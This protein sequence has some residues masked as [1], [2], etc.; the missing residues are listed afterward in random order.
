[1]KLSVSVRRAAAVVATASTLV[2]LPVTMASRASAAT[3]CA[4]SWCG[5]GE[6]HTIAAPVRVFSSRNT[7]P[8]TPINDP[9]PGPI[10]LGDPSP[11]KGGVTTFDIDLLGLASGS[12]FTNPWLPAG[13]SAGDVLAVVAS[14]TV[15]SPGASGYAQAYPA[16]SPAGGS[17]VNFNPGQTTPNLAILRPNAQGMVTIGLA[18]KSGSADVL[19]DVFG[20]FSTSG[21]SSGD[22]SIAR[23]ARLRTVSPG[24]IVDTRQ[25]GNPLGVNGDL[26]V[27]VR[28][29][30]V[31][32]T[33]TRIVPPDPSITGAVLNVTA[34][35]PSQ[36]TYL[37]VVPEATGGNAPATSNLN[38]PAGQNVA[39]TVIVPIGADG[40]VHVYNAKGTTNVIVDVVG[41]MQTG[42]DE[43]TRAGRIVPL[44]A[45][46]RALDTRAIAFGAVPLGP[47]QAEEWSFAS[48]AAS[49]NVGGTSVGN[50]AAVIGNFTSARLG[51]QYPTVGV[52][53]YLS[54]YPAGTTCGAPPTV[55]NVNSREVGSVAN[56]AVF[57]YGPN[58][59]MCVYNARGY[60][61]Y[62]FDVSAVVLAD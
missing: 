24:R 18:G 34:V 51:R 16:G 37:S 55:S 7:P 38:V 5:G 40:S 39:N 45:P 59:T 13:I 25:T 46:F 62:I 33:G 30:T 27:K 23:G 32:G 58:Y 53:S 56:L 35:G 6:Y 10:P 47:A 22:S 26:A 29:A 17:V 48:F 3:A 60:S 15:V 4:T 44:T 1:M 21:Y 61:D 9:N 11:G 31:M 42:A 57:A 2:V 54:A 20:W 8:Y 49:V 14:V 36:G 50:Q 41:Y 12:G 19:V 52:T 43:A 28:D